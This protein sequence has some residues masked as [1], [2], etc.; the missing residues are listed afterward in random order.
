M[1]E[2]TQTLTIAQ[3]IEQAQEK[4]LKE[5][6]SS[7][8]WS[9]IRASGIGDVCTRR[10]YYWLSPEGDMVENTDI[11]RQAYYE[12]GRSQEPGVRRYLSEL[13][14]EILKASF[15]Q[16]WD[17]YNISGK[18]D[19]VLR[20]YIVE[21]K[22][23]SDNA[24][25]AL[26]TSEDFL[27]SKFHVNWFAQLQIYLLLCEKEK[28]LFILKRKAAKQ[29]KVIEVSLDYEYAE[30]L[31]KKAEAVNKAIKENTPPD[32]LK[33][34]PLECK[35]CPFFAKVCNPPMEYGDTI[36]DIQ[37]QELE[38]KL[39]RRAELEEAKKEY[40]VLDKEIKERFRDFKDAFCGNFHIQVQERKITRY[41]VPK[42]VKEQYKT[43]GISKVV[44]I[45]RI[46]E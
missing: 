31:L 44:K 38:D 13:G 45:E 30:S 3:E 32:Y 11:E 25:R 20:D 41:E 15:T 19:G 29:I 1:E 24:W 8:R 37:D 21:V 34:N 26:N 7:G 4:Y 27:K 35:A 22:T 16:R 23:V 10:L 9:G 17:K 46:K 42:E 36:V 6:L 28:G 14:F 40:E 18:I 39:V 5:R 2:Q 33:N 12:E 43:E